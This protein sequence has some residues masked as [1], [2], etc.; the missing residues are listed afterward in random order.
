[1]HGVDVTFNDINLNQE[2]IFLENKYNCIYKEHIIH[3]LNIIHN[4]DF[5]IPY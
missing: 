4:T 5:I 1:M 2:R 3:S